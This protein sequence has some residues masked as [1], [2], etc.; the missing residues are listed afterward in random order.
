[1]NSYIFKFLN[2]DKAY[3]AAAWFSGIILASG[4]RGPE[5]DSRS[6]P[7]FWNTTMFFALEYSSSS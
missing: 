6:G 5:F 1:M 7:N 2:L 4:A 3:N